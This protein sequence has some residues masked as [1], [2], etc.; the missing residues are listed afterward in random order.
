[1]S[2]KKWDQNV[3]KEIMLQTVQQTQVTPVKCEYQIS[4]IYGQSSQGESLNL[5]K[6]YLR[7][8]LEKS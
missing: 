2:T 8:S 5:Y 6:L 3:G 1:M 4:N 7:H